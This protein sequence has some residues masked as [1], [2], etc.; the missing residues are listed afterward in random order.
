MLSSHGYQILLLATYSNYP[1]RRIK[2]GSMKVDRYI[3]SAFYKLLT[4]QTIFFF[5]FATSHALTNTHEYPRPIEGYYSQRG[6]D[7]F[8]NE[9][10]FKHKKNGI[11]VE[12]GA[13]DGISFSNSYF[14]EKNLSWTGICVEPNPNI[15][16]ALKSN[17]NCI[18]E[19]ICISSLN[20]KKPFLVCNGYMLEMYS[21]LIN[22]F[23]PRHL[24]RIE[25]EMHM[26]GGEKHIIWVDCSTLKS[27]FEKHSLTHI[28]FIS[29]DIEGGELEALQSIDFEKVLIDVI[30]IENNFKET[31]LQEYLE[32]K[33]YVLKTR[34]GKD[35]IYMYKGYHA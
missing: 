19:Q 30:V 8:L 23:D 27:L 20:T 33:N 14:F 31:I 3:Q 13:H 15:I 21:G 10:I 7:K 17:R 25:K 1:L 32:T 18:C 22:N 4:G 16:N 34:I 6:Q 29:I 9:I 11:F 5:L 12:I 2:G 35:D 26:F 24:D 28:D